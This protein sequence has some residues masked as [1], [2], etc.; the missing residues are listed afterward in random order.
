M[1]LVERHGIFLEAKLEAFV[2]FKIF[3]VLVERE[4]IYEIKALR[5]DRGG[6]FTSQEFNDFFKSHGIRRPLMVGVTK[7]KNRIILN[8]ARCMLK[9]KTMPKEF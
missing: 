9:A 7:R 4:S 2:A 1:I 8:M 3:K 5:F 6:E